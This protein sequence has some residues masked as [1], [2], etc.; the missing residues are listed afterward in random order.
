MALTKRQDD[1]LAQITNMEVR[2]DGVI[3]SAQADMPSYGKVR[4]SINLE[5]GED[6]TSGYCHGAGRGVQADGDFFAGTFSGRWSRE[7]SM[8]K[9][10]YVV[11]ISNGDKN[12]DI[13][14]F[15]ATTDQLKIEH[16]ALD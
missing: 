6:R 9:M 8:V 1:T 12:L 11:E 2:D 16:Y 15:D 7:G 4:F 5:S 10:H 14:D 3:I 13:V